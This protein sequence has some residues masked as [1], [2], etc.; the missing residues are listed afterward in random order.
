MTPEDFKAGMA[1]VVFHPKW[2]SFYTGDV[3]DQIFKEVNHLSVDQLRKIC[4]TFVG[5]ARTAPL[6]P[7]FR[8]KLL[9]YGLTPKRSH[10][11]PAPYVS[12]ADD[13]VYHLKDNI[14]ANNEYIYIRGPKPSFIAKKNAPDHPLVKEDAEL[15][16]SRRK[17]AKS[18]L[19]EGTYQKYVEYYSKQAAPRSTANLKLVKDEIKGAV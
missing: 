15:G 6:V 18:H 16:P 4:E 10:E 5:S 8:S 7:E 9:E 14:W 2:K 19:D 1:K 11:R 12:T 17:V 3:L 13:L